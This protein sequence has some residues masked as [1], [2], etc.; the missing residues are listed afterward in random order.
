MTMMSLRVWSH[1]D[2]SVNF[3]Q[4]SQNTAATPTLLYAAFIYLLWTKQ[5]QQNVADFREQADIP[6]LKESWRVT[7]ERRESSVALLELAAKCC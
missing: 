7:Q 6:Q 2:V 5:K 3:T 4:R 1:G